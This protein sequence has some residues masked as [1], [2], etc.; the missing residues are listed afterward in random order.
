MS[1]SAI[2]ALEATRPTFSRSCTRRDPLRWLGS[3]PGGRR[4]L[5]T[6]QDRLPA[7]GGGGPAAPGANDVPS[8]RKAGSR[9]IA[10]S[11]PSAS[12]PAAVAQEAQRLGD[13]V[14]YLD[15]RAGRGE[16]GIAARLRQH[17]GGRRPAP[18]VAFTFRPR[19]AGGAPGVPD[20]DRRQLQ[21]DP[22][23]WPGGR[24]PGSAQSAARAR[25]LP[26]GRRPGR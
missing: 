26:G 1:A 17:C 25:T 8:T 7:P 24:R 3:L 6:V 16:G 9:S 5:Q 15:R 20:R 12:T 18:A 11:T 4:E 23:Q 14:Q 22:R 13:D 21:A 2:H 19:P 10:T